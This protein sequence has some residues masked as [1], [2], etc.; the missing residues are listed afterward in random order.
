MNMK[1]W[2]A[3]WV[4][5]AVRVLVAAL[6]CV[7]AVAA[8]PP[9]GAQ[10]EALEEARDLYSQGK[11]SAAYGRFAQLAD[12]G[13]AEAAHIALLMVRYGATLYGQDCAASRSQIEHWFAL[14]LRRTKALT[15]SAGE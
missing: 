15:A 14:S 7:G 1:T 9:T 10:A 2:F 11:W 4:L 5:S 3:Q 12:E 8:A 6:A 13:Q